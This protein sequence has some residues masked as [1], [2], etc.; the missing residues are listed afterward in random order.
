MGKPIVF[1]SYQFKT[2]KSATEEARRRINKYEAG[3]SLCSDDELFFASLFTLH[4]EYELKKG[5]GIEHIQVEQ[6]FHHNRCLYIHRI[7]GSKIDCSWVKCIQPASQ[8]TIVAMAFRRTVKEI[9][10]AFKD[11]Q[12]KVVK[13]CPE[14]GTTLTY[15]N[16]HVSYQSPSFDTLFNNFLKHHQLGFEAVGLTNPTPEDSDQRGMLSDQVLSDNWCQYHKKH[17][18]LRLLSEKANLRRL[19][20]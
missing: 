20:S 9:I 3:A 17:A 10:I 1:G 19:K 13:V 14:L 6:D 11:A 2:K 7:D 8:K 4:H 16:S 12:L 5:A 15:K 18:N